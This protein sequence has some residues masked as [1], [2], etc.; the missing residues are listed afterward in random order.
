MEKAASQLIRWTQK[1]PSTCG[2]PQVSALGPLLWLIMCDG[3]LP[4][5]RP[6]SV[7]TIGFADDIGITMAARDF[8]KRSDQFLLLFAENK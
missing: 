5:R 6:N 1:F 3:V 8:R 4:I 2:V 7:R